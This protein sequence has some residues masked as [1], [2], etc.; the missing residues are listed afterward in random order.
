MRI[1]NLRYEIE[2]HIQDS[3][4]QMSTTEGVVTRKGRIKYEGQKERKKERKKE[5]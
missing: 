5:R 1:A 2:N 4:P 3:S